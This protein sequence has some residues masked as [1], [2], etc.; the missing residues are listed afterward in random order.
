MIHLFSINFMQMI[1]H[2]LV[3]NFYFAYIIYFIYSALGVKIRN[4]QKL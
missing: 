3:N 1:I 4:T 2:T